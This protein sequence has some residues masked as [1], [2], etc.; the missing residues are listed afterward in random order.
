MTEEK[1]SVPCDICGRDIK[2]GDEAYG[3]STGTVD[4]TVEGFFPSDNTEY[5]TI[6]CKKCGQIISD[7]IS[8][9]GTPQ[10]LKQDEE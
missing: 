8:K 3:T 1:F 9:I 7:R 4:V 6:A 10:D 2:D 5:L